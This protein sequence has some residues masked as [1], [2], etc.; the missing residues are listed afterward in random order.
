MRQLLVQQKQNPFFSIGHSIL[1]VC[2]QLCYCW[3]QTIITFIRFNC[4]T[5]RHVHSWSAVCMNYQ[6]SVCQAI[7]HSWKG[8]LHSR[9]RWCRQRNSRQSNGNNTQKHK[10]NKFETNRLK[11][12]FKHKNET[13]RKGRGQISF[14]GAVFQKSIYYKRNVCSFAWPQCALLI[15]EHDVIALQCFISV[16]FHMC[17]PLYFSTC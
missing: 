3:V 9:L 5:F 17:E 7:N 2:C 4:S 12:I 1:F 14:S 6:R 15:I 16:L 8:S 10:W 11:T 13:G